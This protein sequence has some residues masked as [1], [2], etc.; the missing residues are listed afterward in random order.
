MLNG[1]HIC[2]PPCRR[3]YARDTTP[4][5][6]PPVSTTQSTSMRSQLNT[7]TIV[8]GN[9]V[10]AARAGVVIGQDAGNTLTLNHVTK[11]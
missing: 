4:V 8:P 9:T 11:R 10:P 3:N 2:A 5:T 7:F 1:R 6:I